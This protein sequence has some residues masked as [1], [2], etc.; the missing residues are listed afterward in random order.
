MKKKVN[1][2]PASLSRRKFISIA[3]PG[4]AAITISPRL[5]LPD[6]QSNTRKIRIGIT[7]SGFGTSFYFHEHP[8]C[9]VEAVSD[10]SSDRRDLLMK[11][12][13]CSKSYESH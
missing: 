12:Y 11:V 10:L 7:G 3:G 4:A 5:T 13:K 6:F 2:S 1:S 9:I 8:D